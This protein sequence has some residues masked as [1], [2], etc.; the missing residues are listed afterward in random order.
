MVQSSLIARG[1]SC[2]RTAAAYIQL[3]TKIWKGHSPT[4]PLSMQLHFKVMAHEHSRRHRAKGAFAQQ[5][6]VPVPAHLK[7]QR[8]SLGLVAK[9]G[10]F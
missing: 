10:Q 5:Q 9:F 3:V 8:A 7:P 4:K 2:C 6:T 1:I